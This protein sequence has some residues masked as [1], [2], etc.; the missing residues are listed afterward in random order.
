MRRNERFRMPW[1]PLKV[2]IVGGKKRLR[3][4]FAIAILVVLVVIVALRERRRADIRITLAKM[5]QIAA[6]IERY[7]ATHQGNCPAEFSELR[8]LNAR[9][10]VLRDAW[11]NYFNL[12]CPGI[13]SK[14]YLLSSDGPDREA[15]GLD[16]IEY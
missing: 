1:S 11:G 16:R 3:W 9:P 7:R 4:L 8:E 12:R 6:A 14:P 10:D 15:G 5:A 13:D 2:S